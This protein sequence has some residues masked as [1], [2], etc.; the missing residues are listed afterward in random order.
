MQI[1]ENAGNGVRQLVI[2]LEKNVS[3]FPKA[4]GC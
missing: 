3:I 1:N 2:T 4:K